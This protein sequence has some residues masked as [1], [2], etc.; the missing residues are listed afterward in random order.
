M[1]AKICRLMVMLMLVI[2]P[3]AS[4]AQSVAV[5]TNLLY[6]ALL[7]P[8][9][10]LEVKLD[11][12]MT[13]NVS[14][15]Y[16]P[17]SYSSDRKWKNWQVQPE[18]RYWFRHAF[19]GPFVGFCTMNGGFNIND[20]PLLSLKYHRVQGR[21]NGVGITVGWHRIVSPHWSFEL[22]L[23]A[24]YLHFHYD[25]YHS[26]TFD[27]QEYEKKF[28]YVGPMAISFAMVYIIR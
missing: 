1:S 16:C 23:S 27:D 12:S 14:A 9:L 4:K 19:N 15:T 20:I 11:S 7:I 26:G 13:F 18:I 10:G 5:K 24:G 17:F 25:K 28:D 6:D 8:S 2:I 22:S 21:F 3:I